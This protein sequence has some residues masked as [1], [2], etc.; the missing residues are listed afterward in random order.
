MAEGS[1][2]YLF[3]ENFSPKLVSIL[4]F[5]GEKGLDTVVKKFEPGA[6]DED[7]I[8]RAA[9]YGY[10]FITLD[11][12]QLADESVS[13]VLLNARARA[14]FLSARFSRTGRWDQALWLLKYWP[15]IKAQ[16]ANLQR[17]EVR[18]VR[19]DG[20]VTARPPRRRTISPRNPKAASNKHPL[21]QMKLM[22]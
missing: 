2:G 18:F 14:V 6:K 19:W 3:D 21:S 16:T 7:W 20:K 4:R 13:R 15:G 1:I 5:L 17:G 10:I 11:R 12:N 9:E 22:D 8:P